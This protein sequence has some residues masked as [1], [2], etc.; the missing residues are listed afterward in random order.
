[1]K[2][3]T[4]KTELS[5]SSSSEAVVAHRTHVARERTPGQAGVKTPNSTNLLNEPAALTKELPEELSEHYLQLPKSTQAPELATVGTSE[6]T[7]MAQGGTCSCLSDTGTS[8]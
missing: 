6:G 1:M 3:I 5:S 8:L 7:A 4:P 2:S